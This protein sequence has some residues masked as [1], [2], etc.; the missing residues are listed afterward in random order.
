MVSGV[1]MVAL[2]AGLMLVPMPYAVQSPGPTINTMGAQ[3]DTP[4]ITVDGAQTFP[5][6]EGELRL[7]TV[8]VRGGPSSPATPYDVLAGW[9]REDSVVIPREQVFGTETAEELSEYQQ[10]QMAFQIRS[11]S[12]RV[13]PHTFQKILKNLNFL[14][15]LNNKIS[16]Y[17]LKNG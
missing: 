12:L 6:G 9:W 8:S 15:V 11:P 13:L 1:T 5:V 7:T 4:I 16:I 2:A 3:G 14:S 10:I 17:C